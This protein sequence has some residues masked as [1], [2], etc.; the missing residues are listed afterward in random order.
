M[1][2]KR[3][4]GP[5]SRNAGSRPAYRVRIVGG[6]WKRTP[7][8]VPDAAGLRPT[9]DRVRETVF[10]WLNHLLPG[11]WQDAACLD[12]FAGTGALGFEAASRGAGSVV[13]LEENPVAVKQLEA[14][15]AKL[16]ARQVSIMRGDA[17]AAGN[18]L[19]ARGARFQVIFLDPPY[20]REWLAR[21]LPLCAR[22]I[23]GD[24]LLYAESEMRLD[25]ETPPDWMAGWKVLRVDKAGMVFYHMLQRNTGLEFEA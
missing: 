18:A 23:D 3:T 25:G 1:L 13:M 16:N 9:P 15:K 11:A 20:H 6:M 5:A 19:A 2:K 14:T 7:L 10:N 12:L 8:P 24:G 22:L 4:G 21:M 17:F